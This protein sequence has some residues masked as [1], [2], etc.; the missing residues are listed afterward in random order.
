V[1]YRTIFR[2]L[3]L[4]AFA[5]F[6]C[7][8]AEVA[9]PPGGEVD[10]TSPKI[11]AST[12]LNGATMVAPG[13]V[14]DIQFSEYVSAPAGR[15]VYISPRQSREP[16]VKWKGNRL[17]ITLDSAFSPEKT[18]V[19]SLMRG[20]A[21]LRGN[22]FDSNAQ[23]AF[24][25]GANLDSGRVSGTVEAGG[26]PASGVYV[27]L[28]SIED[29]TKPGTNWDSL[30]PIYL[31][32]TNKSGEF[33]LR[34]LPSTEFALA[35]FTDANRN[36]RINIG[37]EPFGVPDRKVIPN[38][39]IAR[40]L[41]LKMTTVDTARPQILSA[42]WTSDQL[43]RI[44]F[45][46]PIFVQHPR[47]GTTAVAL[48]SESD[49][50]LVFYTRGIL[51][52][53]SL[54]TVVTAAFDQ[55]AVG[56]YD[57]VFTFDT[58]QSPIVFTPLAV[59]STVDKTPPRLMSFSLNLK[60]VFTADSAAIFTFSE[61]IDRTPTLDSAFTL[62]ADPGLP[63]TLGGSWVDPF[64]Y[65]MKTVPFE[66]GQSYS[67][68]VDLT[69][70]RDRA[71]NACGDSVQRFTFNRINSD[72]LGT[73]TGEVHVDSLISGISQGR[74][75]KL[76]TFE[77]IGKSQRFELRISRSKFTMALPG[78]KYVVTTLVDSDGNGQFTG[79][80]LIPYTLAETLV[81][82]PDTVVV[83]PRFETTGVTIRVK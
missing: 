27:G 52:S 33:D 77:R 60:T 6:L 32:T 49:S 38:F 29:V 11:L 81:R 53:D 36:D 46:K 23:V 41:H 16:K 15:G 9:P 24:S 71:G 74:T 39:G 48:R 22:Q 26:K 1:I 13:S 51:E 82:H 5:I 3:H 66:E 69:K 72:S 63:M 20:L 12:P 18:Y 61:P 30:F 7:G 65:R 56:K 76:V 8:C 10:K 73:V 70:L 2:I 59:D 19:V 50:T 64:R 44:R 28:F 34:Y 40:P 47:F 78:G 67:A 45:A 14:I 17:Q 35:T 57:V 80:R 55:L 31:T 4:S 42:T 37:V 58:L 62:T 75:E 54:T 68:I 43:L 21:D 83:R 79:G 25:T